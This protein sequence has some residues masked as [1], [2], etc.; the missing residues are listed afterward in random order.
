MILVSF[1][2]RQKPKNKHLVISK[3]QLHFRHALSVVTV[4]IFR[5]SRLREFPLAPITNLFYRKFFITQ[6]TTTKS[7]L[8]MMT[9]NKSVE[10][11]QQK[12]V[13]QQQLLFQNC[14]HYILSLME[15]FFF[16]KK[17]EFPGQTVEFLLIACHTYS[18]S[19][20]ISGE[21]KVLDFFLEHPAR[22]HILANTVGLVCKL[23]LTLRRMAIFWPKMTFIRKYLWAGG[24]WPLLPPP[25]ELQLESV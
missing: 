3:Q 22:C 12:T 4:I 16:W 11:L 8:M 15:L 25:C 18:E 5:A 24:S 1:W 6:K 2:A 10:N 23:D 21:E 20:C 14:R 13:L 9:L 19:F 17:N 7:T